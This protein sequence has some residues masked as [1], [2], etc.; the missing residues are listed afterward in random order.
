[1]LLVPLSGV[2]A[3][4]AAPTI[5]DQGATT[6]YYDGAQISGTLTSPDQVIYNL[7]YGPVGG[8]QTSPMFGIV[9]GP[10]TNLPAGAGGTVTTF[11]IR[12]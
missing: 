4:Q 12:M 6:V 9:G 1:V 2:A 5:T 8:T 10:G 3:A 7:T 11:S